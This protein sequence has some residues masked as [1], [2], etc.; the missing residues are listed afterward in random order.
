MSFEEPRE[1]FNFDQLEGDMIP[2]TKLDADKEDQE[3]RDPKRRFAGDF[4]KIFPTV[5]GREDAPVSAD[6]RKQDARVRISSK[7]ERKDVKEATIEK[8]LVVFKNPGERH[9]K[10]PED[11]RPGNHDYREQKEEHGSK[12]LQ[13]VGS[14]LQAMNYAKPKA[15]QTSKGPV[16]ATVSSVIS[17]KLKLAVGLGFVAA[18]AAL[19]I[20]ILV[21]YT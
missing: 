2:E 3:T 21:F 19:L 8:P 4:Q 13:T 14:V 10:S 16:Q 20:A 18:F 17:N 11:D 5:L 6:S 7:M 12:P 9:E 1:N 15:G